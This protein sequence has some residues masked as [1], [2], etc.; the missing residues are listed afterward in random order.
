VLAVLNGRACLQFSAVL[1][2]HLVEELALVPPADFLNGNLRSLIGSR[3]VLLGRKER[4]SLNVGRLIQ[5]MHGLSNAGTAHL[6]RRTWENNISRNH[7]CG[8]WERCVSQL[9]IATETARPGP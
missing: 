5:Q 9:R 6:P 4:A 2:K 3:Q 1:G 8:A 7:R